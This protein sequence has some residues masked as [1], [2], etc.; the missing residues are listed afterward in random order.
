MRKIFLVFVLGF[1]VLLSASLFAEARDFDVKHVSYSYYTN[2]QPYYPHTYSTQ[3]YADSYYYQPSYGYNYQSYAS[4][5]PTHGYSDSYAYVNSSGVSV[6]YSN[7]R[8][9]YSFSYYN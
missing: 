3:R 2:Q 8:Y 4:T 9:N 5:Y 7:G 1:M 6:N